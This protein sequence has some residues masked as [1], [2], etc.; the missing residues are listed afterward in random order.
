VKAIFNLLKETFSD[1]SKDKASRLAAAL[2]YYT[3][4][5]IT[6]LLIIVISVVGLVRGQRESVQ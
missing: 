3:G 4:F 1:W 2:A 5:S 6:P